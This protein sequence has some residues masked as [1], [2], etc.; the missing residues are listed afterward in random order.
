MADLNEHGYG[1][2]SS[3]VS[4]PPGYAAEAFDYGYG[5]PT[6]LGVGTTFDALPD[7]LDTGYGSEYLVLV[8]SAVGGQAIVRNDGAT[9]RSVPGRTRIVRRRRYNLL[10]SACRAR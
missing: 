9:R 1:A 8:L 2:P 4:V 3:W 10:R 5:D 7:N 6:T